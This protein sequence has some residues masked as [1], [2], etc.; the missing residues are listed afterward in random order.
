MPACSARINKQPAS[1]AKIISPNS[2]TKFPNRAVCNTVGIV[3]VE[4]L[5]AGGTAVVAKNRWTNLPQLRCVAVHPPDNDS[6]QD[7]VFGLK[8]GEIADAAFMETP[9]VIGDQDLTSL[10]F[11]HCFQ[12]NVDSS[13][14]SDR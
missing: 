2:T 1:S 11:L 6:S 4:A 9:A 7:A 8:R 13:K 12:K 5:G 10:G 14:M 3:K